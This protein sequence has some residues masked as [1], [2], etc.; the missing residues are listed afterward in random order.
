MA[1]GDQPSS[2]IKDQSMAGIGVGPEVDGP[3]HPVEIVQAVNQSRSPRVAEQ[4]VRAIHVNWP[5]EELAQAVYPVIPLEEL[6]HLVGIA[7]LS[8]AS[9][10]EIVVQK[11]LKRAIFVCPDAFG[12][13][14]GFKRVGKRG[15]ADVVAQRR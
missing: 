2:S 5:A 10:F 8:N 6:H 3:D 14:D 15:V 1:E 13:E 9:Q 12:K 4:V 7:R 11:Q